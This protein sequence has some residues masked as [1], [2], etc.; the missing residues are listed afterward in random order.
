MPTNFVSASGSGETGREAVAEAFDSVAETIPNTAIDFVVAFVSPAYEYQTVVDAIESTTDGATLIGS[1]SAGEFT[2]EGS[3]SE[4]V[5][6]AAIK[7]D[8]MEF[9]V[10]LGTGLNENVQTGLADAADALDP[11][12]EEYPFVAGINIHDGLLGI[13]DEIVLNAYQENPA[14][15]VGGSAGDDRQ[16]EETV[17]FTN[18]EIASNAA[19]LALIGSEKPFG[20]AVAHGHTP[21]SDGF[22]VTDADGSVVN[23]L[24][25]EQALTVWKDAVSEAVADD[26]GLDIESV[27]PDDDQWV[28]LLTQYEFGIQ[29]GDEEYKVRWPGLTPDADGSLHFAT[30]I[31]EGTEVYV[32][33]ADA[34]DEN[35]S[36]VHIGET[37]TEDHD[38]YAGALI[39]SCICQADILGSE[40]GESITTVSEY[41]DSDIAGMEVYGEVAMQDGDMRGYHNATTS[42]LAFPK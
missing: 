4:T 39:F 11:I 23:E 25:G 18:D 1:S 19:A 38:E 6:V 10:G 29:T 40:F 27:S 42:A 28:E 32:M 9:S 24:D 26:H 3:V 33:D 34:A 21:I 5:T 22:R 14:T 41:I 8:T 17:V 20:R 35:S 7:S 16:L 2:E 37:L 15:Y 30:E 13:G 36:H 31:P 12:G